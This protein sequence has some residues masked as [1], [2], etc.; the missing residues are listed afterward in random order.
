[1]GYEGGQSV[2]VDNNVG[3]ELQ[4]ISGTFNAEYG[5]AMSGIVNI[6]TKDGGQQYHF[7]LSTYTGTYATSDGWKFDGSPFYLDPTLYAGSRSANQLFYNLNK[8][9]PFDNYNV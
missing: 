7:N 5:Q 9:R 4:V 2:Q 3:Q 6:V 1:V 8:I